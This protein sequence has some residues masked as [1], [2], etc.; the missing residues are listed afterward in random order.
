MQ[1]FNLF[2]IEDSLKDSIYRMNFIVFLSFHIKQLMYKDFKIY[3]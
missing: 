3:D 2:K 1:N